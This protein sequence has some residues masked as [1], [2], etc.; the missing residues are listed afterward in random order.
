M[1]CDIN[2]IFFGFR[3]LFYST[4][5]HII[6]KANLD[7]TDVTQIVSTGLTDI[8]GIAIDFSTDRV[9]WADYGK[10]HLIIL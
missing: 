5:Q 8:Y 6:Y 3:L 2:Y 1:I 4:D 10:H 7:G 9:C